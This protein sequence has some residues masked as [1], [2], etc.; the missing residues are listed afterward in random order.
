MAKK[1][2][3]ASST[4]SLKDAQRCFDKERQAFL[5]DLE[6]LRQQLIKKDQSAE[7]AAAVASAHAIQLKREIAA[8][9][10]ASAA[11]E[12][13]RIKV[14][15]QFSHTSSLLEIALDQRQEDQMKLSC[16]NETLRMI[17]KKHEEELKLVKKE[18]AS[19]I[20]ASQEERQALRARVEHLKG[21]L[22]LERKDC[23]DRHHPVVNELQSC[24]LRLQLMDKELQDARYRE[25]SGYQLK[26]KMGGEVMK[27]KQKVADVSKALEQA[28]QS[29]TALKGEHALVMRQMR[30][31]LLEVLQNH[32]HIKEHLL[33]MQEDYNGLLCLHTCVR[34]QSKEIT[35]TLK[36]MTARHEQIVKSKEQE[37]WEVERRCKTLSTT[38]S[39]CCKTPEQKE[40]DEMKKMDAVREQTRLEV[41]RILE[42]ERW[43]HYQE[44]NNK[45]LDTNEQLLA[46][47]EER[48]LLR[49]NLKLVT[50]EYQELESR[51]KKVCILLEESQAKVEEVSAKRKHDARELDRMKKTMQDLVENISSLTAMTVDQSKKLHE[52]ETARLQERER[53]S[54]Q[55]CCLESEKKMV[56]EHEQQ[57]RSRYEELVTEYEALRQEKAK[58]WNKI[59]E[60]QLSADRLIEEQ[61]HTIDDLLQAKATC[62]TGPPYVKENSTQCDLITSPHSI[63]NS[64]NNVVA[65]LR[66]EC[67]TLRI[68]I[69][70]LRTKLRDESKSWQ[71]NDGQYK[72]D[73]EV[74][75][76]GLQ[77]EIQKLQKKL[78]E[79]ALTI[80]ELTLEEDDNDDNVV[81]EVEQNVMS[82]DSCTSWPTIDSRNNPFQTY[83]N[84]SGEE[85]SSQCQSFHGKTDLPTRLV[86]H[87]FSKISMPRRVN[88]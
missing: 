73:H 45:Y 23:K 64:L 71:S 67:E 88:S 38:C 33:M 80:H 31:K 78:K 79:Q 36:E 51:E 19:A 6:T 50:S 20:R 5:R 69:A 30:D 65:S 18:A 76:K 10:A 44:V 11:V 54:E 37:C 81:N 24:K 72:Y 85:V 13:E 63:T 42:L 83:Q 43:D 16:L 17:E 3:V 47:M 46:A 82:T 74:E 4:L 39:K 2:S 68:E 32:H 70:Q 40:K 9:Q 61:A 75:V 57:L 84:E 86:S 28:L 53:S 27:Y 87:S 22:E 49:E 21:K 48:E 59:V 14:H 60:A 34:Q 25:R 58:S 66:Q 7:R 15:E 77:L 12:A 1:A 62:G 35:Q 29:K 56:T 52:H 41:T 8:L 26:E 55:I